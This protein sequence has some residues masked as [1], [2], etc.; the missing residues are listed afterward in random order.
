MTAFERG[1]SVIEQREYFIE[2]HATLEE[3]KLH[4]INS[5]GKRQR[6]METD[7]DHIAR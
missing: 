5:T 4:H 2:N 3:R 1:P 7:R 6:L